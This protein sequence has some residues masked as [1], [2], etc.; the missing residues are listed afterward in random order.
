LQLVYYL[1]SHATLLST[2]KALTSVIGV[3]NPTTVKN[4]IEFVENT[5][6]LFQISRFDYSLKSQLL[7]PKKTYFIDNALVLKLGFNFSENRGRL[8]EN[9]VFIELKRR[10]YEIYYHQGKGE[11]D[12]VLRK[13]MQILEAIQVCDS[14]GN[15]STRNREINGLLEAM[16]FYRL[17]EGWV[18]TGDAEE[19]IIREDLIIR[20]IP[21]WK[22]LLELKVEIN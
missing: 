9:L 12:F 2:N 7:N 18:I 14:F 10:G 20:I 5:Y 11:C 3:K 6:F 8:L 21:A 13:G 22:W 1:A 4:Y 19:T 17:R 16:L 15:E